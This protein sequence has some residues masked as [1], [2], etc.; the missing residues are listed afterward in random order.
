MSH[1]GF[2]FGGLL[3]ALNV[4]VSTAVLKGVEKGVGSLYPCEQFR[5]CRGIVDGWVPLYNLIF[6]QHGSARPA[7]F[8]FR[9]KLI[10]PIIFSIN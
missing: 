9:D 5:V 8:A 10:D 7:M 2:N 6:K 3:P 1:S 4:S